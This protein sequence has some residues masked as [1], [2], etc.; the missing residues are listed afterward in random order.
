M[1]YWVIIFV[2]CFYNKYLTCK[3]NHSDEF[4]QTKQECEESNKMYLIKGQCVRA[5]FNSRMGDLNED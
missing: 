5:N 1:N 4:Y 3:V 2:S